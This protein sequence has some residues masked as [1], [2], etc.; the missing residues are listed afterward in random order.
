M[1]PTW[2][3]LQITHSQSDRLFE[4]WSSVHVNNSMD[5]KEPYLVLTWRNRKPKSALFRAQCVLQ[6]RRQNQTTSDCE[7][8][9]RENRWPQN[10]SIIQTTCKFCK[11]NKNAQK[12]KNKIRSIFAGKLRIIVCVIAFSCGFLFSGDQ[13]RKDLAKR[14]FYGFRFCVFKLF[15][16]LVVESIVYFQHCC[17]WNVRLHFFK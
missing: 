8:S 1:C 16:L 6:M 12:K 10:K 2:N 3:S 17:V 14:Y 13:G 9:E 4:M 11:M 7:K 5:G 15:L